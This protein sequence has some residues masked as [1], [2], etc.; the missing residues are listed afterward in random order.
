MEQ[1]KATQIISENLKTLFAYSMSKLYDKE[2]AED[3]TNDIVCE[4]LKSVHRLQNEEAFYGFMWKI[5]ENT[6]RKRIRKTKPQFVDF[7]DTYVGTYWITPE[8]EY[9]K[10][11]EMNL[12]R[13]E[14]SLLSKQY[15]EVTVSYY[16]HGK[17]CSDIALEFDISL[18][19]VKYY[20]FKTRKLLKEGFSMT[21]EFGEK[22][23]NPG[24]FRM[25]FWGGRN[26]YF[27][28]FSR[29]LPGNIVLFAY[30]TPVTL[31]ELSVELGVSAVYLEEEIDILMKHDIIRKIGEKY[32]TN[33]IIFTD[34]YE[35]MLA[36]KIRPIYEAYVERFH[37]ELIGLLPKLTAFTFQDNDYDDNRLKWTFA[38]LFIKLA[39][40][41]FDERMQ[42]QLG[43]YPVLSNGSTGFI[44][45][46]D[47]DYVHHHFN[48]IYGHCQNKAGSAYFSVTNYRIIEKCQN[49][50]PHMWDASIEAMC[51]AV[52]GAPADETNE[53][54]I[55]LI[56]DGFLSGKGGRLIA[57]FP[58]FT[59]DVL[60]QIEALAEP[61]IEE[62][63][64]CMQEI[65]DTATKTLK[66][67]VPRALQ[68]KC[69]QLACIHHQMDAMA[70]IIETMVKRKQL[71]VPDEKVNLCIY[72]V[73]K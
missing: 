36:E 20:L 23:Y 60:A 5:A 67:Y 9:I 58:V 44:F 17:S 1:Q 64:S 69:A 42:K 55:Q 40:S 22:S 66:D 7:D 31:Q 52:L 56:E 35:K 4:I 13:R 12:L 29:K 37:A 34:A 11:E 3:L 2:Q 48:G 49:W 65:C 30:D 6:F 28:L 8:E 27:E 16:I 54:L 72:G 68:S 14:L 61:L 41:R 47:N 73:Q 53:M 50:H 19:M 43:E 63:C 46:Y 33:I 25:D 18:E 71:I 70:F 45:G 15:R 10:T 59:E 38:N 32:Q 26:S 21:R 39:L 62:V 57:N 51:D 24:T